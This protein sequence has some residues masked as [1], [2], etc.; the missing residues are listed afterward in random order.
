[1]GILTDSSNSNIDDDDNDD[2]KNGNNDDDDDDSNDNC[3]TLGDMRTQAKARLAE[4]GEQAWS[5]LPVVVWGFLL[6]S[7]N[8][9]IS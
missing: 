7:C 3:L 6:C 1:M 2:D 4:W 9:I 8:E 5:I